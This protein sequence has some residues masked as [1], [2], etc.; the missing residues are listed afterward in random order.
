MFVNF[1]F[2]ADKWLNTEGLYWL[3]ETVTQLLFTVFWD[4]QRGIIIISAPHFTI[5]SSEVAFQNKTAK[6]VFCVGRLKTGETTTRDQGAGVDNTRTFGIDHSDKCRSHFASVLV[7]CY[8]IF[9]TRYILFCTIA[10]EQWCHWQSS[11]KIYAESVSLWAYDTQRLHAKLFF[12]AECTVHRRVEVSKVTVTTLMNNKVTDRKSIHT[13]I[14][15]IIN[16]C[17]DEKMRITM[18]MPARQTGHPAARSATLWTQLWQKREWPHGTSANPLRGA[19]RHTSRQLFAVDASELVAVAVGTAG[20]PFVLV[21]A[22]VALLLS[23][24]GFK[25]ACQRALRLSGWQPAEIASD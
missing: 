18:V 25:N 21:F 15:I 17:V 19:T 4:P 22:A 11:A 23:S 3:T 12:T 14:Q 6:T 10:G 13:H 20:G 7:Y 8:L 1:R 5:F 24:S 9:S 16:A 2:T